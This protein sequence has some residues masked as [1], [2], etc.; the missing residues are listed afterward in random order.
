MKVIN[1]NYSRL[2]NK[3]IDPMTSLKIYWLT[4]KMFLNNKKIIYIS[5]LSQQNKYVTDFKENTEIFNLSNALL[6]NSLWWITPVN[7]S[8]HFLKKTEKVMSS[9]SF[10]S[11]N[12]T[13]IIWDLDPNKAHGH[14]MISIRMLK[15]CDESI[16][17]PLVIIFKSC[18]GKNGFLVN[19]KIKRG[20]SP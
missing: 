13:K 17:K 14:D 5:P 4:L 10:S 15:I 8:W 7:F 2:S 9:I 16:L 1:K 6:S 12:I 11:K 3:L 19:G 18:I 20:S